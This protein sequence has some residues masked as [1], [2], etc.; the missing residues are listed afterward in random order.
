MDKL[1]QENKEGYQDSQAQDKVSFFGAANSLLSEFPERTQEIIKKR[2]GLIQEKPKTLE[3]IGQDYEITRERV[4]Q[5]ITDTVNKLSKK[6]NNAVFKKAEDRIV[7]TIESN[8]GIIK[9]SEAIK[10]LAS[11]DYREA[12]SLIFLRECS[13]VILT[14]EENGFEKVWFLTREKFEQTKKTG[15]SIR[16]VLKNEKKLFSD[17]E[18]IKRISALNAGISEKEV[19]NYASILSDVEKNKFGKWGM[20]DWMEI[21]P[22]GTRE[23][24]YAILKE[25]GKPLH[26]REIAKLID[27]YGLSKKKA[28]VQTVHNE[29]IKNDRFVLIGRGIYALKEWGYAKGT[30]RDV[31]EKILKK[32]KR[33]LSKEEILKEVLRMRQVKKAT[34]LINLSNDKLFVKQ[35]NLYSAREGQRR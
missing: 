3:K 31:L 23:R 7:F 17:A 28:H 4:R 11:A 16:E 19:M 2:F 24:I 15:S 22:K 10:K 20:S 6:R 18:L 30:I 26:F 8:S 14:A 5:I 29:L 9:E 21:R 1:A 33:S 27:Q 25:R 35:N 32:S 13:S 34:V 12:N